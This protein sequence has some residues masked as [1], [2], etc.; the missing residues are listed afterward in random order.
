MSNK[1]FWFSSILFGLCIL[2]TCSVLI[3]IISF[4]SISSSSGACSGQNCCKLS[5]TVNEINNIMVNGNSEELFVFEKNKVIGLHS[6]CFLDGKEVKVAY[7][8]DEYD[9]VCLIDSFK[10]GVDYIFYSLAIIAILVS[11]MISYQFKIDVH[12]LKKVRMIKIR[13]ARRV[14]ILMG[15]VFTVALLLKFGFIPWILF[16]S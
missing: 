12:E 5:H 9:I 7:V 10:T 6:S 16:I 3:T 4:A 8:S 1:I 2:I 13:K 15:I 11:I 14:L